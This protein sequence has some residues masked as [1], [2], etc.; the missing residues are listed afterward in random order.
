MSEPEEV[1]S[2]LGPSAAHRWMLCPG[3]VELQK[4]VPEEEE[5]PFAAEGTLAHKMAEE[6]LNETP[7]TWDYDPE[8]LHHVRMYTEE[9]ISSAGDFD[10]EVE[11]KVELSDIDERLFGTVDAYSYDYDNGILSVLDLKYGKGVEVDV[12]DNPQLLYYAL[13][14]WSECPYANEV[15]LTIVQPRIEQ[16]Q[17]KSISYTK[18]QLMNFAVLLRDA[19]NEVDN[20]PTKYVAGAKQCK[21]CNASAICP[22]Q[23]KSF[24]AITS[25][26]AR[27]PTITPPAVEEMTLE[28]IGNVYAHKKMLSKWLDD[29][30]AHA[31]RELEAGKE[32]PGA[33]LV[34]QRK[35]RIIPDKDEAKKYLQSKKYRVKDICDLNLKSPAKLEAAG[36][37]KHEVAKLTVVPKGKLVIAPA[38]D[39]RVAEDVKPFEFDEIKGE[40]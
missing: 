9:V 23:S 27:E 20:N 24:A 25:V 34:M 40:Q 18:E 22:A 17:I 29:V 1:H 11:A 36:I 33:K 16:R 28:M 10:I 30:T 39:K 4:R 14:A 37:P 3:S 32:V 15:V 26:D 5:S 38:S 19:V 31:Q 8:M 6:L 13:C 12:E 7:P 35:N 21:W 2:L